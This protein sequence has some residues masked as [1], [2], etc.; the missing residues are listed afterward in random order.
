MLNNALQFIIQSLFNLFIMAFLL[1]F[2][3]QLMRAPYRNPFSQFIG[4]LTNF[5]VFPVRRVIPG[6]WGLDLASLSIAW[7]LQLAM[8]LL[9]LWLGDFPLTVAGAGAF[10]GIVLWSLAKLLSLSLYLLM[11][12]VIVQALLSWVNPYTPL[13]PLLASLT[14]PFLRPA[15]QL[16]PLISGIDLSPLVVL[17]II[18]L[19]LILPVAWLEQMAYRMIF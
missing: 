13:A 16:I 8:L 19:L 11:G 2:Y 9:L 12:A 6:L 18:Q 17:F 7:L 3:L 1:R 4:A 5:A 15:R 14:E 10:G